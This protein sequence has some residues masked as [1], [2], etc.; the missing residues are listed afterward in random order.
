LS[1]FS[2]A[3]MILKKLPITKVFGLFLLGPGK[4]EELTG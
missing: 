2:F 3:Q 4:K 1:N